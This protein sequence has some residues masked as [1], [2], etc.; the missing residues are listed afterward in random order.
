MHSRLIVLESIIGW[1][2]VARHNSFKK[3]VVTYG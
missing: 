2:A 3:L 1:L